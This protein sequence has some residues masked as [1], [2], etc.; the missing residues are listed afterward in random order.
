MNMSETQLMRLKEIELDM[1]GA[2]I[3]CCRSLHL[4]YYLLGGTLLGAVRHKGFIPWDDDIDVGMPRSDYEIFL[5][6]A[7]KLLPDHYFIQSR[8]S[9][10]EVLN[11]F[12]KI[13]DSRTTFIEKSVKDRRI[14]HGVYI[15]IFPL[16]YYPD[17]KPNQ[18]IFDFKNK[19]LSLRIREG[20]S[21][22]DNLRHSLFKERIIKLL[23]RIIA[24]KYHTL[25]DALEAREKLYSSV[26]SSSLIA[27]FSG[28]WK[29][30]EIVPADWFGKGIN[31]SFEGYNVLLPKAYDKWL[32]HVYGNYMELPPAEKRVPHHYTEVIDLDHPYT[33]YY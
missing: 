10:P 27:N 31:G 7:Q 29:R 12:A 1:L 3:D 11:N 20:Y 9:D 22:P 33:D 28:T 8:S 16:D 23:I 15:D 2:F 17:K 30:K 4:N 25:S 13:R 26:K 14:H 5:K 6:E 32:T 19:V 18:L 24:I 21:L